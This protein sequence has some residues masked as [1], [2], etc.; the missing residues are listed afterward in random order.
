MLLLFCSRVGAFPAFLPPRLA[1]RK[2]YAGKLFTLAN[3]KF[4][5]K[6]QTVGAFPLRELKMKI[7]RKL[8]EESL[9]NILDDYS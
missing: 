5:S 3:W 4:Q 9:Q 2:R 6:N 1:K 7:L 8:M